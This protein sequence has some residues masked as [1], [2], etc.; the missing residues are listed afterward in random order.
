M[1]NIITDTYNGWTIAVNPEHNMCSNF[2]FDITDPSG[3]D[4]HVSMGGDNEK[5]AFERAK[6]MIDM[7]IALTRE[8]RQ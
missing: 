8:D 2:S 5:R 4:K 3:H 1:Q 6:E 7:E